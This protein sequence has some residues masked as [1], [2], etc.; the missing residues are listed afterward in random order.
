[1]TISAGMPATI[2]AIGS[3][4]EPRMWIAHTRHALQRTWMVDVKSP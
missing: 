4:Q 2:A 3:G 1:M